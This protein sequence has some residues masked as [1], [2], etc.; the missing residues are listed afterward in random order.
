[1]EKYLVNV[2][3]NSLLDTLVLDDLAQD[4]AVTTAND[5]DLLGVGVGVHGKVGDHFL[6][7]TRT[8]HHGISGSFF[9]FFTGKEIDAREGRDDEDV[10]KFVALGALDHIVQDQHG[11]VVGALKDE[12]ILVL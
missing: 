7:S 9:F 10:R 11:A 4:T 2:A 8:S 6:V 1:M 12:H 3:E 5:Q